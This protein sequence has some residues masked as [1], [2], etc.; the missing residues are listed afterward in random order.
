V[1][2]CLWCSYSAECRNWLD[3]ADGSGRAAP[4]FCLNAAFLA[5]SVAAS[6]TA[7]ETVISS[8]RTPGNPDDALLTVCREWNSA[9]AEYDASTLALDAAEE[10]L[11][12]IDPPPPEAL[13]EQPGDRTLGLPAARPHSSA[14]LWYGPFIAA[15][16][17]RCNASGVTSEARARM[18]EIIVAYD[19]WYARRMAAEETSGVWRAAAADRAARERVEALQSR[20]LSMPA[21][22]L[23]ALRL[24]A[25][26]AVWSAGGIGPLET[27]LNE[28][29]QVDVALA[30]SIVRD[31]LGLGKAAR[32]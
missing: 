31:L 4:E 32:D 2:N 17:A 9:A 26:A 19:A 21:S 1:Q 11:E 5:R 24:K 18:L 3:A 16:R 7:P 15:V 6:A 13:F 8:C 25:V 12:A 20:M 14:R 10:R 30:M 29:G 22:T 28:A 27:D 23:E